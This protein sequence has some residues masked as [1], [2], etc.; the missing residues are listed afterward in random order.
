[1]EP[2]SIWNR[3]PY[4]HPD[5]NEARV[6]ADPVNLTGG[7]TGQLCWHDDGRAQPFVLVQPLC[8]LPIVDR[9]CHGNGGVRIVQA[10]DGVGAAKHSE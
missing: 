9:A 2:T 8:N 3:R 5:L 10:V 4:G 6:V 1:M 7:L